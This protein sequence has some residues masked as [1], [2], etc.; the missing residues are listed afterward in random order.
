[1]RAPTRSYYTGKLVVNATR[2]TSDR[3]VQLTTAL[4]HADWDKLDALARS[5]NV[6]RGVLAREL[7][8]AALA[9][10]E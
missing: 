10:I 1:M 8:T 6:A 2:T 5:R 3:Y 9:S 7:L 4:E